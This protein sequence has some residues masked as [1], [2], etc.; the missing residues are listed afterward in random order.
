MNKTQ[1]GNDRRLRTKKHY[2]S[3]G[4]DVAVVEQAKFWN[5]GGRAWCKKWDTFGAD[6]LC[7]N[8]K[9]LVFVQCKTENP[10]KAECVREFAKWKYPA[11]TNIRRVIAVWRKRKNRLEIEVIEV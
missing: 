2:E 1:L 6:L 3:L 8:G 4:Y 9:E 5:F 10:Q 7:M 11:A